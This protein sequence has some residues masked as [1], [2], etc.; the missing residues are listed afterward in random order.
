MARSE[1]R[2]LETDADERGLST[3]RAGRGDL[4]GEEELTLE[5]P[6]R[7]ED[8][9]RLDEREER[10]VREREDGMVVNAVSVA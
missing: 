5:A 6:R 2:R 4:E 9:E 1:R 8:F 3:A 10:E 7:S